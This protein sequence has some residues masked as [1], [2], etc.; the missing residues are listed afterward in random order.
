MEENWFWV[1]N[2]DIWVFVLFWFKFVGDIDRFFMLIFG[3]FICKIKVWFSLD[4][5]FFILV[6]VILFY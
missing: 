5:I 2:W 1:G 6:C 4:K 3:V